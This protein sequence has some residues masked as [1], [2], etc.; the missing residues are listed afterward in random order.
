MNDTPLFQ[1][2]D[3]QEAVYGGKQ[4]STTDQNGNEDVG[5]VTP[6]SIIGWGGAS[7]IAGTPGIVPPAAADEITDD[8]TSDSRTPGYA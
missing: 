5:S 8:T 2:S 7:G 4:S 1:H 6:P 3:E